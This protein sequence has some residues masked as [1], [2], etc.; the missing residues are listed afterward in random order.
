[1]KSSL[2]SIITGMVVSSGLLLGAVDANAECRQEGIVKFAQTTASGTQFY[3]TDDT[4][5]LPTSAF[6]YFAPQNT[7]FHETLSDA[8]AAGQIVKVTGNAAACPTAGAF[9]NAGLV[10]KVER[11]SQ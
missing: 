8:Q 6:V 2:K 11:Y 3:L 9:R 7:G 10:T 5:V 1:M 4:T